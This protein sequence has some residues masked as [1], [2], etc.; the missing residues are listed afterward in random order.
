MK[1]KPINKNLKKEKNHFKKNIIIFTRIITAI[2]SLV[3]VILLYA[4]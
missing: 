2:S 3:S 4:D 1:S